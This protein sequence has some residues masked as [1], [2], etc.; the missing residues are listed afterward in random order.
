MLSGEALSIHGEGLT[1]FKLARI[2]KAALLAPIK[3]RDKPIGVL[4]VAH[5]EPRPFNERDQ[6]MLE[7]V[8]DY[9]SI[10]LVNSRLFQALESR[11]LK[12]QEMVE[13]RETGVAS[14]AARTGDLRRQVDVLGGS[15]E[16]LLASAE[17]DW[18][19][20]LQPLAAELESLRRALQDAPGEGPAPSP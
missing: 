12:L 1:K 15:I 19:A 7:A 4:C 11:A 3:V 10:S 20:Q 2:A 14:R 6:S 8:A 17:G 5:A 9:A 18:K 13:Q 16:R